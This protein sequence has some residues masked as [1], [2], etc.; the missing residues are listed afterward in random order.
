MDKLCVYIHFDVTKLRESI[1][2][3]DI[4]INRMLEVA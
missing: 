4:L 2:N 3:A 1:D